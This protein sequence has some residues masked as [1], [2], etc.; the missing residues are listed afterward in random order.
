M[1]RQHSPDRVNTPGRDDMRWKA[2]AA[3]AATVLIWASFLV[4]TRAAVTDSMGPVEVAL[5]RF[6]TGAVLFLPVL[7]RHG[8]IPDGVRTTD[9]VLL[10]LLGGVAFILLLAA[11][12][13]HAPV[14]DPPL[15]ARL[16][17]IRCRVDEHQGIDSGETFGRENFGVFARRDLV[18]VGLQHRRHGGHAGLNRFVPPARRMGENE[19]VRRVRRR[20]GILC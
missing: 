9:L 10:P 3:L 8:A 1:N 6:G 2:A 20:R 14:A 12:L 19:D 15:T 17:G 16:A 4:A 13:R 5:V 18:A 7:L 11:G